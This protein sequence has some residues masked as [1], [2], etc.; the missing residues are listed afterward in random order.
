MIAITGRR[1]ICA[2]RC[3]QRSR[4]SAALRCRTMRTGA[5]MFSPGATS[6]V[7]PRRCGDWTAGEL[8]GHVR[9]RLANVGEGAHVPG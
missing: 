8:A 4:R 3:A 6:D 9:V 7:T 5:G 2:C 1:T